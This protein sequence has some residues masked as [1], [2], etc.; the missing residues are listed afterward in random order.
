[1]AMACFIP[2]SMYSQDG[3]IK[4]LPGADGRKPNIILIVADDLGIGDLGCYGQKKIKTPNIDALAKSGMRFNQFYSGT[5]VCA[6]SRASLMTGLHTGHTAIRGN[7]AMEPEGQ[8]PLPEKSVTVADNLKKAGYTTGDFGKWGLGPVGSTGDPLKQGFDKFFGYNCQSQA[9][10][11]Y[12]DHLWD[13]DKKLLLTKNTVTSFS[14]YAPAL[15]QARAKQFLTENADKPFFL[16]LSYTLPHAALQVP[17]DSM[18]RF[19]RSQFNEQPVAVKAW[20]GKGYAP[21]AYPK[22]AY[23]TMVSLLDKYVGEIMSEVKARG[24]A[25]NTIIIFT[26][27]NGA[28]KEGGHDPDFFDSNLGFRG[29]K[30]DL[31]EGGVRTPMIVSWPGTVRA[32]SKSEYVGAFWD[33]MPTFNEVAGFTTDAYTDGISFAPELRSK[34]QPIHDF[35]YWE[36]HE[37]GGRQAVRMDQWKAVRQNVIEDVSAPIELYDIKND[38]GETKN[39]ARKFPNIVSTMRTVMEQQHVEIEDFPLIGKAIDN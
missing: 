20:T 18:F 26:S 19:Y 14:D 31:Y 22:A 3:G 1:M 17:D 24:I 5:S 36:F 7:R 29:Y 37:A 12:P 6:P 15:I 33:L 38:P 8:W 30:R 4:P 34:K 35:L 25:D 28:H 10:N 13:Q 11:Y 2:E 23:A 27:D 21:Q 32:G 16:F 39:V 9:H